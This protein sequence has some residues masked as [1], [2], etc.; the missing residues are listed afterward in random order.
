MRLLV[1]VLLLTGV[2][3]CWTSPVRAE[4]SQE[5]TVTARG[6][7][8]ESPSGLILTYITDTQVDISWVKGEGAENTMVRAAIGRLPE[9][10]EDGYLIYYGDGTS[11]TD[12]GLNLD[13][14]AAP[15]Y[16]RA[17]SQSASEV[18][19]DIGISE[20]IEGVGVKLIAFLLLPL[21]TM[22][23]GYALRRT[24]LTWMSAAGWIIL[25]VYCYTQSTQ[26]WDIMY[27]LFFVCAFFTLVSA[28]EPLIMKERK[29]AED[30]TI[31]EASDDDE[32]AQDYQSMNDEMGRI[33]RL[34][35]GGGTPKRKEAGKWDT[36]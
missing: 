7:I 36:K 31:A 10:R 6:F 35:Q 1:G 16:Y 27:A 17:W 19:E 28:L 15:V 2:C 11:T 18:W 13:E 33:K 14:I 20:N 30:T 32:L 4:T 9:N 34:L 29:E 21:I 26:T 12:T 8:C 5:V 22:V 3:L 25:A 24:V 23:A